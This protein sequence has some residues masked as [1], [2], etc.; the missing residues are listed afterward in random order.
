MA[1]HS[2]VVG[3][4]RGSER[5]HLDREF[6]TGRCIMVFHAMRLLALD[7]S[8]K[9]AKFEGHRLLVAV[10]SGRWKDEISTAGC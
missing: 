6:V 2:V 9:I 1:V 3:E 10:Q 8:E 5:K 4:G 7:S